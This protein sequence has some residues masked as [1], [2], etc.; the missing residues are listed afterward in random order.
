MTDDFDKWKLVRYVVH[1]YGT[2]YDIILS[3]NGMHATVKFM[4]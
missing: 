4:C 1:V 3:R 2:D